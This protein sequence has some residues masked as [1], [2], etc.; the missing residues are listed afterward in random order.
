[1]NYGGMA[2][3]RLA[4][5]AA[6]LLASATAR[7]GIPN[8]DAIADAYA[9]EYARLSADPGAKSPYPIELLQLVFQDDVPWS[10]VQASVDV[11]K[12]SLSTMIDAGRTQRLQEALASGADPNA[13]VN[14]APLLLFAA[15]CDRWEIAEML[16]AA[17][18]DV[19]GVDHQG[20]DA[21]ILAMVFEHRRTAE[22]LLAHGYAPSPANVARL[23]LMAGKPE[24]EGMT[25]LLTERGVLP[26][27]PV[28]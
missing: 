11:R 13:R 18:A 10:N 24:H 26:A 5:I 22:V 28:P 4:L 3:P 25:Q 20:V 6:L 17:G 14:D 8:C 27:Q 9:G 2:L 12:G 23:R 19:Q 7:A 1:M 15:S 16:L 21:M